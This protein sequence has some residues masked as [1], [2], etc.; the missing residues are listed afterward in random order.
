M[1]CHRD[2]QQVPKHREDAVHGLRVEMHQL[3]LQPL[4]VLVFDLVRP[5]PAQ[6][7]AAIV[8]AVGPIRQVVQGTGPTPKRHWSSLP[9]R[10]RAWA[11]RYRSSNEDNHMTDMRKETDSLGIVEVPADKLWGAAPRPSARSSTSASGGT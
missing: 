8:T 11:R 2:L 4:N 9:A 5:L 1:T 10:P 3:R 6:A 7:G